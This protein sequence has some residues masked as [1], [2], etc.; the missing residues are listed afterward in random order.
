MTITLSADQRWLLWAI[1]GWEMRDCLLGPEGTDHFMT[2]LS[3]RYGSRAPEGAPAWLTGWDTR[4][5]KIT[6]PARGEVRV[7]VTA[8]QIN[9][10]AQGLST[11]IRAQLQAC[12]TAAQ[13]EQART[14]GWCHC[15]WPDQTPNTHS[16]P[17]QRFHPTDEQDLDHDDIADAIHERTA[18]VLRRALGLDTGQIALF[19]DPALA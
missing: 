8:A 7:V 6:A 11:N 15:P 3:S 18:D 10:F 17:C 4:N 5:R 12:R 13:A 9:A 19:D 16:R 2:S 14:A 1:G